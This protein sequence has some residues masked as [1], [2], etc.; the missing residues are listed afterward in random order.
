MSHQRVFE[1]QEFQC[2]S[3]KDC[4]VK[5]YGEGTFHFVRRYETVSKCYSKWKNNVLFNLRCKKLDLIPR[6]L[7]MK[8][9][10]KTERGRAIAR[11]ASRAFVKERLRIAELR[12]RELEEQKRGVEMELRQRL[13]EDIF[14]KLTSLTDKKVEKIFVKTRTAQCQKFIKLQEEKQ[15]HDR[16]KAS[17]TREKWVVNLSKHELT[18]E[19][20]S[21]LQKDLNF[22]PMQ[23]HL[24]KMNIIASIEP[25]L[26]KHE[27][28]IAAEA[29]RVVISGILQRA[30][31]PDRN[32]TRKEEMALKD[33]M[34]N[35]QIVVVPA[36]KGNVTVVMDTEEYDRKAIEVIGEP[37][38][39]QINSDP[40][41]KV[42][43][44]VN[45][46]VRALCFE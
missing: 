23:K 7:R 46:N 10:I 33:L 38:F 31:L 21:V 24:P 26:R 1:G 8:C 22:A 29:T 14:D 18:A 20:K 42:E 5:R 36:D 39:E 30:R 37:P 40:S 35:D 44:L 2:L 12:K 45:K 27:D 13:D 16:G 9:P 34:A 6:S 17:E 28:E 25:A 43:E 4:F 32:L 15:R 3:L 19:E 11:S 41:R